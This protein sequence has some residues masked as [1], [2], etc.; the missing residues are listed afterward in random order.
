M[1]HSIGN[2][3]TV[4]LRTGGPNMVAIVDPSQGVSSNP[5]V[6]CVWF[7]EN[8]NFF[9]QQIPSVALTM[10]KRYGP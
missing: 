3:D 2:G 6:R 7:D 5:A 4:R 10:I 9:D 1:D 8:S